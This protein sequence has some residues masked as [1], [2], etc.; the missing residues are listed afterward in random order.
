[1]GKDAGFVHV[2]P[3][4]SICLDRDV[5]VTHHLRINGDLRKAFPATPDDAVGLITEQGFSD[6][7]W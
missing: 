1:M 3:P 2:G 7:S 4:L 5:G 6:S